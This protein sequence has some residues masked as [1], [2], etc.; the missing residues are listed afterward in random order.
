MGRLT[1]LM[2]QKGK[3]EMSL[4]GSSPP[5]LTVK[6]LA[7][8]NNFQTEAYIFYQLGSQPPRHWQTLTRI[9]KW[10][11]NAS[12]KEM[13]WEWQYILHQDFEHE[14][15][16]FDLLAY[17]EI[18]LMTFELSSHNTKETPS[19]RWRRGLGGDEMIPKNNWRLSQ[20][21]WPQN[22]H[23]FCKTHIFWIFQW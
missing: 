11:S 17:F 16:L 4:K 21:P 7:N 15:P 8:Y 10:K 1:Q 9:K 20:I 18:I 23:V 5:I 6:F 3:M 2:A 14:W 13:I 22:G 19:R 12:D